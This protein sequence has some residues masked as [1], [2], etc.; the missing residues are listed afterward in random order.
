MVATAA[1]SRTDNHSSGLTTSQEAA[2]GSSSSFVLKSRSMQHATTQAGG[3]GQQL[4]AAGSRGH[5]RV[6]VATHGQPHAR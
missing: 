5:A 4:Q 1:S 3:C 6:A 2:A